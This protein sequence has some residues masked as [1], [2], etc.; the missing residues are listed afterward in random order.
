MFSAEKYKLYKKLSKAAA[1]ADSTQPTQIHPPSTPQKRDTRPLLLLSKPRVVESPAPLAIYNPFSPVKNKG[2]QVVSSAPRPEHS[3]RPSI[4][5]S[6]SKVGKDDPNLVNSREPSPDALPAIVLFQPIASGSAQLPGGDAVSRARKR[7]R[8][9]P[10]SPSPNKEKRRRVGSSQTLL[11]F[12][13]LGTSAPVSDVDSGDD[14]DMD[15]AGEANSS[16]VDDSPVKAPVGSKSFKLLFEESLPKNLTSKHKQS[17]SR[18]KTTPVSVGISGDRLERAGTPIKEDADQNLGDLPEDGFKGDLRKNGTAVTL[19]TRS[20][21]EKGDLFSVNDALP[22]DNI[23]KPETQRRQSS[24]E[25]EIRKS[26][27][28][29]LLSEDEAEDARSNVQSQHTAPKLLPPSPLPVGPSS[30]GPSSNFRG[31]GKSVAGSRKKA[32]VQGEIDGEDEESADEGKVKLVGRYRPST[33]HSDVNF[34]SDPILGH[35]LHHGSRDPLPVRPQHE[36]L[37][38]ASEPE[39]ETGYFEVDLPDKLRSVLAI[40]PSSKSRE[41]KA[42]RVVS[43]LLSGTRA[44]HYDATKGGEIWD[45]GENDDEKIRGDTEGEDDWEGEGMPWEVA[46]L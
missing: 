14:D 19:A 33:D 18:S 10:V 1:A 20:L 38:R 2:K 5:A 37:G 16:F 40:S 28:R 12:A 3:K 15:D 9:E 35:K 26:T 41:S 17:L 23:L 29:P 44:I 21:S 42:E 22:Y 27:K 39:P 36:K 6:P 24:L 7:L 45:A 25:S 11:P 30:R 34:D 4:F 43:G 46:E 8:G 32:K 31:K 13:K